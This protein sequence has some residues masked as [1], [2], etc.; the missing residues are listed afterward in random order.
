MDAPTI[1]E[2]YQVMNHAGS[3]NQKK[4]P[5]VKS[6]PLLP[7]LEKMAAWLYAMAEVDASP[8]A[9]VKLAVETAEKA[10][11]NFEGMLALSTAHVQKETS[12]AL[13]DGVSPLTVFP[14]GGYGYLIHVP[15]DA[16]FW[17][18]LVQQSNNGEIPTELFV[19]TAHAREHGCSWLLLDAD[20]SEID[21]LTTFDA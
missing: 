12:E 9:T 16:D 6:G 17:E 21:G 13:V 14:H 10:L 3:A 15:S 11:P 20:A 8:A 5:V 4:K 7:I 1:D 2:L 18:T 19:C